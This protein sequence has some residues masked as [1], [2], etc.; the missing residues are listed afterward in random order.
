MGEWRENSS[1]KSLQLTLVGVFC[2]VGT[3][4][5]I[6]LIRRAADES[7]GQHIHVR[8]HV[9]AV[10][11]ICKA[12]NSAGHS[13]CAVC[14]SF[15]SRRSGKPRAGPAGT[16]TSTVSLRM[17]ALSMYPFWEKCE[18]DREDQGG[19]GSSQQRA[20]GIGSTRK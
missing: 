8:I 5:G 3:Y 1:G 2:S 12:P 17:D 10:E 14:H 13:I 20:T 15:R 11:D 4:A 16:V 18:Q 7:N 19:Y 9:S 6:R